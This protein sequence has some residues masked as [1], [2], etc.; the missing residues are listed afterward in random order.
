MAQATLNATVVLG[1]KVDNS[2][3][4]IGQSLALVGDVISGISRPLIDFGKQSLEV[5]R[6][7]EDNMLDAQVAL[8]TIYGRGTRELSAVMAQL[9]AQATEW[10]ASSIF[11]T[12]DVSNAI[13]QAAHANWDLDM[14]LEGIPAAMRLAQAGSIDLS[15]AI[16]YIVKSTNAM[17]IEFEDVGSF[18][19]EWTYA[20]NS[21]AGTVET[22]GDAMLRMGKSMTFSQN[23]QELLS[24]LAILHDAGSTGSEAGTLLRNTM[25]RL[26]AP[27]DKAEE[28]MASLKLTQA[29][30]DEAMREVDGDT[31]AAIK[32]LQKMGFSAYDKNG[33]LKSFLQIF[34]DLSILVGKMED[35]QRN[36]ILSAIFPTRTITGALALLDELSDGTS[37][38]YEDLQSGK[39]VG[40]GE[41]GAETMMSGLTGSVE[42]LTSKWE[43]LK[44]VT[45]EALS[46]D[47]ENFAEWAGGFVDKVSNMPEGPFNALVTGLSRFSVIGPGLATAGT[48]MVKLGQGITKTLGGPTATLI[49]GA[50]AL[51]SFINAVDAY[52]EVKF[53]DKFGNLNLDMGPLEEYVNSITEPFNQARGDLVEYQQAVQNAIATYTTSSVDL[54]SGLLSK[55]TTRTE[56]TDPEKK[57]FEDLGDSMYHSV[58]TGITNAY[59]ADY[60]AFNLAADGEGVNDPMFAKVLA[61]MEAGYGA[62]I[63]KAEDL[64]AQL[65]EALT[66]AF[67][68]GI[69]TSDELANIQEYMQQLNELL[70]IETDTIRF[71]EQQRELRKAQTLGIEN[72]QQIADMVAASRDTQLGYIEDDRANMLG[73]IEALYNGG[74]LDDTAKE[75]MNAW[76]E[77]STARRIGEANDAFNGQ[78]LRT[79]EN[80][81]RTSDIGDV[82]S[83]MQE[84]IASVQANGFNGQAL[85]DAYGVLSEH[86]DPGNI[87]ALTK[88]LEIE[89][90]ALG[91]AAAVADQ[92]K[93]YREN[94]DLT[95][96]KQYDD[97][98]ALWGISSR[99][100]S[101]SSSGTDIVTALVDAQNE[102]M[103]DASNIFEA[104]RTGMVDRS[105]LEFF[106]Q[107]LENPYS[108]ASAGDLWSGNVGLPDEVRE[109]LRSWTDTLSQLYDLNA[110]FENSPLAQNGGA[111][112]YENPEIS[113]AYA[114][115]KL[116]NMSPDEA[117]AYSMT[118]SEK[119]LKTLESE[120]AHVNNKISWYE[121]PKRM[122]GNVSVTYETPE[123]L[124]TDRDRLEKEIA[125]KQAQIEYE[126][127]YTPEALEAQ[128][129]A[130]DYFATQQPVAVDQPIEAPVAIKTDAADPARALLESILGVPIDIPLSLSDVVSQ[131]S[132]IYASIQSIFSTPITQQVNI[133]TSGSVSTGASGI[134]KPQRQMA[135]GGRADEPVVFGEAGPEWFIPEE[136]SKRTASLLMQAA[137]ASGYTW[138]EIAAMSGATMF[139]NGGV[140]GNEEFTAG[141]LADIPELDWGELTPLPYDDPGEGSGG[142]SSASIQVQYSPVINADD[143]EGVERVLQEDKDR[144][145]E[146]L[147][148][149]MA[150]RELIESVSKY[151]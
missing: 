65:K 118:S 75:E 113:S 21:S 142:D 143:A 127:G 56:L 137:E 35:E 122:N 125:S 124:T 131:A 100:G 110:V 135:E 93:Y 79:F 8:S 87:S 62:A 1:G 54:S 139:A 50:A 94:G 111:A 102:R 61:I 12:N 49:L 108:M 134:G 114:A 123:S 38:L 151:R 34:S 67:K 115:W 73:R 146:M 147:E 57:K 128:A 83:F 91:G 51:Y 59:N 4:Q 85:E 47:V 90:E 117:A 11:H 148:E 40:Y 81:L 10:A 17:G 69:I 150:E 9:D 82:F 88:F 30:V 33:N 20:A 60:E 116:L 66:G 64:N 149:L 48:A 25:I 78:V 121:D 119:E 130:K 26:V 2:F 39:A 103:S 144:L 129:S 28:A 109:N 84:P 74:F 7:Y 63:A 72:A 53:E 97:L 120:L 98:L 138:D 68:D 23:R 141:S 86:L 126:K 36:D 71:A 52:N 18:I 55:M 3:T 99:N 24:M 92:A 16:N 96:A 46:E 19:D 15:E 45:G 13:A 76:V 133:Q 95:S 37:Q 43:K 58:L 101:M 104:V 5:Y 32:T 41:Y 106:E 31:A 89:I 42:T 105:S 29:D 6:N 107:Q 136:H 140:I 112:G 77:S 145:K 132:S 27:T 14:I 44:Q 22:F 70:T 80:A